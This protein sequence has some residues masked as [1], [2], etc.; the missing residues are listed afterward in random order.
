MTD[1][2]FHPEA[3][4]DLDELWEFIARDNV[5]AA[6]RIVAQ[7]L[8]TCEH[9]SPLPHQGHHRPELTHGHCGSL[10]YG[11]TCW[12]TR[13]TRALYG[14]WRFCMANAIPAF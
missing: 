12:L 11:I 2:A 14:S 3:L 9:L 7:V 6:D 1:Y 13:P 5:D 4:N 8:A 10:L